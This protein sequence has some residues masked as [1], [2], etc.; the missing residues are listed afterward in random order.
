MP[1]E[2]TAAAVV[3]WTTEPSLRALTDALRRQGLTIAEIPPSDDAQQQILALSV[4]CLVVD[5]RCGAGALDLVAWY[6]AA[7]SNPVLT[8]TDQT[9]VLGRIRALELQVADHLVAPFAISEAT[10]RV[11]ALLREDHRSD[12]PRFADLTVDPEQQVAVRRGVPIDLTP[13][14]LGVLLTLIHNRERVTSKDE[15]LARVWPGRRAS[16]NAVE[17]VISALR[18]KLHVD[19]SELIHTVHRAGYIL[20]QAA[21]VAPKPRGRNLSDA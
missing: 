8:I 21:P 1:H 19:G 17:A 10:A 12:A 15:L 5:L 20:R 6:C 11:Q 13:R 14:E 7:V 16:I 4:G 2:S 18:R 3:G 9:D